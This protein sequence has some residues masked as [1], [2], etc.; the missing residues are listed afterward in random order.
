MPSCPWSFVA[1]GVELSPSEGSHQRL[2][3][4][5]GTSAGPVHHHGSSCRCSAPDN[6]GEGPRARVSNWDCKCSPWFLNVSQ[7]SWREPER[8]QDFIA[9]VPCHRL[10]LWLGSQ[11]RHPSELHQFE[12]AWSGSLQ[13]KQSSA[14]RVT[15]APC[16]TVLVSEQLL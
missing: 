4:Q 14:V 13:G 9:T 15:F 2:V 10:W 12:V 16:I 6:A 1:V 3:P 11:Q 5:D 7:V 8:G